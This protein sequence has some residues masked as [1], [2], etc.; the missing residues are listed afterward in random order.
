MFSGPD[1]DEPR[2]QIIQKGSG[3]NQILKNKQYSTLCVQTLAVWIK[4]AEFAPCDPGKIL[5]CWRKSDTGVSKPILKVKVISL[6]KTE[7]FNSRV[8][9]YVMARLVQS[10]VLSLNP[11]RTVHVFGV[12]D[13]N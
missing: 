13:F 2:G 4:G 6:V 1:R 8:F 12:T 3:S 11:S 5:N 7:R 10:P 9:V